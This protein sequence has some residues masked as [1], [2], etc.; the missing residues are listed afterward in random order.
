MTAD[1]NM[2]SLNLRPNM[3]LIPYFNEEIDCIQAP[4]DYLKYKERPN[5][6]HILQHHMFFTQNA[7]VGY[8][9][10]INFNRMFKQFQ[11]SA[12]ITNFQSRWEQIISNPRHW[13]VAMEHLEVSLAEYLVLDVTRQS[14]LEETLDQLWGQE[15]RKLM[16]PLKVRIG[17]LEGEVGLDQGGVTYEF[18]RL[19]LNEAFKPENGRLPRFHTAYP[20]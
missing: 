2:D 4:L 6:F 8:F 13:N 7:L 16:K 1:A 15:K 17:I 5:S 11:K 3:F 20:C 9:R 18:F 10:A 14:P 12:R 19:I